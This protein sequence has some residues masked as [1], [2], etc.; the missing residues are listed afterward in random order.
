MNP[1]KESVR[2]WF[3]FTRRERRSTFILL[4]IIAAV[5]GIR[6]VVPEKNITLEVIPLSFNEP[7]EGAIVPLVKENG[8]TR[9]KQTVPRVKKSVT[10]INSC[11]SASFEALPGIGPV[12][13]ARIVKYRKL[14]GGFVSVDQL[15]EVYGLPEETFNLVSSG[16]TVDT[17]AI[18]KI[19]VNK[20]EFSELIRHPYF[21]RNEEMQSS[22]SGS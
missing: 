20:A 13:S 1:I 12:L 14:I 19:K 4:L 18:K 11:D 8:Y 6:Y 10:E 5:I 2:S 16:L 21:Q 3:G 22:N 17:L 9:E 15:R 7:A